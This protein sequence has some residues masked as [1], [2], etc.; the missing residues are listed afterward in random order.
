VHAR[1]TQNKRSAYVWRGELRLWDGQ[2]LMGY[3][4][5]PD[6]NVRSKGTMFFIL[7]ANGDHAHGRWV[8]LSYDAP[9]SAATPLS[10]KP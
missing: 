3:H 4:A 5:A 9:S 1:S 2:V 10:P 8:G 6:G 7:H